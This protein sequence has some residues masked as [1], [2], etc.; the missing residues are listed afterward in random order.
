MKY[1]YYLAI[2]IILIALLTGGAYADA[3]K[4]SDAGDS[5]VSAIRIVL[6][7]KEDPPAGKAASFSGTLGGGDTIDSYTI[8][9]AIGKNRFISVLGF[10]RNPMTLRIMDKNTDNV[11]AAAD[12]IEQQ[13]LEFITQGP[14]YLQVE[15]SGDKT[16]FQYHLGVWLAPVPEW[17]QTEDIKVGKNINEPPNDYEAFVK[18]GKQASVE[19]KGSGLLKTGVILAIVII[20]G[21][22]M[23]RMRKKNKIS[24]GIS[25]MTSERRQHIRH[26]IER[27]DIRCRL[28]PDIEGRLLNLCSTGACIRS[29]KRLALR[30]EYDMHIESGTNTINV[31]G[32]VVWEKVEGQSTGTKTATPVYEAGIEFLS[33]SDQE[34]S[35]LDR[36]ISS[37]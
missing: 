6:K 23:I 18:P 37:I 10:S 8:S 26:L 32:M 29:D 19:K 3:G 14:I 22:S 5:A 4:N 30:N 1:L 35:V 25:G 20:I 33:M 28:L 34:K 7:D 16:E 36:F 24:E 21:I 13:T 17:T 2:N 31:K 27:G 11:L 12:I 15:T 9:P